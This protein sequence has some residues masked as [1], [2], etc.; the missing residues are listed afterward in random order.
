MRV[1]LVGLH[2][3][4]RTPLPLPLRRGAGTGRRGLSA[5]IGHRHRAERGGDAKGQA[6]TASDRGVT[7]RVLWHSFV[8]PRLNAASPRLAPHKAEKIS[9]LAV[10]AENAAAWPRNPAARPSSSRRERA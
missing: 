3:F 9:P 6:D 10:A 4:G 2:A 7:W 8:D 5:L 1:Q